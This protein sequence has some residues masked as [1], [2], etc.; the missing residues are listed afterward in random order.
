VNLCV[1]Y[2]H[3][4]IGKHRFVSVIVVVF[5]YYE[6]IKGEVK[7]RPINECGCDERLKT[8]VEKLVTCEQSTNANY[9]WKNRRI[10]PYML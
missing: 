2:L 6:S 5:L 10:S 7:T 8:K 1:F 9:T 3:K 4:I